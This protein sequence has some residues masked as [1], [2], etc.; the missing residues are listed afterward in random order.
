MRSEMAKCAGANKIDA[1]FSAQGSSRL[2]ACRSAERV[3]TAGGTFGSID[4]GTYLTNAD[5]GATFRI[6]GCQYGYN[7]AASS[8]LGVGTYR[9]DISIQGIMVGHAVFALQ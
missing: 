5:S 9:V 6:D 3:R 4:E 2:H 7:L 8:L 1:V